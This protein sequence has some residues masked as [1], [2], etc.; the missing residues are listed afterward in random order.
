MIDLHNEEHLGAI[1]FALL[2]LAALYY[3]AKPESEQERQ[4][5]EEEQARANRQRQQREE[6]QARAEAKR[7]AQEQAAREQAEQEAA[8]RKQAKAEQWEARVRGVKSVFQSNPVQGL[9]LD[10]ILARYEVALAQNLAL[11][12]DNA[13]LAQ[14]AEVAV[15]R[16]RMLEEQLQA[17]EGQPL[18]RRQMRR[19]RALLHPDRG[20]CPETYKRVDA[21]LSGPA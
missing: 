6:A 3:L 5:R 8:A 18:S 20:G 19:I 7:R 4:A 15:G 17:G 9:E 14:L 12:E 1:V 10:K 2:G 16:V 13:R 21:I 11:E